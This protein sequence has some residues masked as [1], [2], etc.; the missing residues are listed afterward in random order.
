MTV[1]SEKRCLKL[2]VVLTP[3]AN[4]EATII[5][6]GIQHSNMARTH[7]IQ[8]PTYMRRNRNKFACS[9]QYKNKFVC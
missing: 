2:K 3:F 1:T 8:A 4:A 5:I 6:A 7:I 9:L